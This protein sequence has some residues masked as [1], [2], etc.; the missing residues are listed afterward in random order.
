MDAQ[1]T[2]NIAKGF[3]Y[4]NTV[5]KW[6][7]RLLAFFVEIHLYWYTFYIISV[8]RIINGLKDAQIF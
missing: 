4:A 6:F 7:L 5:R 3:L 2:A 1:L 8:E